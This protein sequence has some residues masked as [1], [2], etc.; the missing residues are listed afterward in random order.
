MIQVDPAL[1]DYSRIYNLTCKGFKYF[2]GPA[3]FKP[4]NKEI[5]HEINWEWLRR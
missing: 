3:N 5:A 4:K 2:L 1:A